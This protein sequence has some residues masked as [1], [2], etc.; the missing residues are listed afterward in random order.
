MNL[1]QRQASDFY[2]KSQYSSDYH[3]DRAFIS[4]IKSRMYDYRKISH[5]IEFINEI[6][7]IIKKEYDEHILI[8]KSPSTCLMNIFYENILFFLQEEIED[9]E[10]QLPNEDFNH[11]QKKEISAALESIVNELNILKTGQKITYD[12]LMVEFKD[13][14]EFLYLE[15]KTLSQLMLGKLTEVVAGSVASDIVSETVSKSLINM[16]KEHYPALINIKF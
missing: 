9:L 8:C 10:Q 1:I 15:K 7:D 14:R 12:D 4:E 11:L 13:L 6:I 16:I 5:K 3:Q 2:Q